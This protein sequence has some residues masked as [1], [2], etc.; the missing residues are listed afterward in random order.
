MKNYVGWLWGIVGIGLLTIPVV[1]TAGVSDKPVTGDTVI[2]ETQ[3]AVTATKDY[4]IQQKDAFQRKV[5][6]ELDEMQVRIKQLRGQ[7]KHASAEA[8]ADIQKAIGELE[9]KKDLAN[10]KVKAIHSA[11]ASSWEQVKSKAEAAMDDLRDSL[12][13]ARSYLPSR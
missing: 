8:R 5:Q 11:T 13:R 6:T 7:V 9:K 12:T 4:T 3:E 10:K 1:V 2:R